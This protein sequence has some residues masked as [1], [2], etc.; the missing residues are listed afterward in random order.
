MVITRKYIDQLTY[1]IVGA[2]IKVHKAI[3]PGL[4][5]SVYHKC[6]KREFYLRNIECLSEFNRGC[7]IQRNRVGIRPAL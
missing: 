7:N 5:E 4:L 3:G 1:R 2:A 6:L